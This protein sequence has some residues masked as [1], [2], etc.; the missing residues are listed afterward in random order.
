MRGISARWGVALLIAGVSCAGDGARTQ[1]P[2]DAGQ[3]RFARVRLDIALPREGEPTVSTE[4]RFLRVTDMDLEAAQVLAGATA[5][6]AEMVPAGRCARFSAERLVDDALASASPDA[7]VLMLDAGD[8]AVL[9]AG[10]PER[11]SPRYI[12][13]VIPFVSGVLYESNVG[14]AASSSLLVGDDAEVQVSGFGG[15]DVGRFDTQVVLPPAPVMTRV[16]GVD[17]GE[18]Q[19]VLER[20][21]DLEI[22]WRESA[23]RGD[24]SVIVSVSWEGGESLRCRVEGTRWVVPSAALVDVWRHGDLDTLTIG[25]ER[26]RR[27]AW[28]APGLDAADLVV[29]VRDVVLARLP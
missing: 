26:V 14:L 2:P 28:S 19:V 18:A 8:V 15:H 22:M 27:V 11:L 7:Q 29:S 5:P 16:A 25:V 1:S 3:S 6:P 4:A 17:P 13:E 12:P 23:S 10:R 20:G 21:A 9:A 24:D